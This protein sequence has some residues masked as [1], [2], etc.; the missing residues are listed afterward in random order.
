LKQIIYG[1]QMSI[2]GANINSAVHHL[3]LKS[4]LFVGLLFVI[5]CSNNH[6]NSQI[7]ERDGLLYLQGKDE[8]FSGK[9]VDTLV[10]RILE[11]E[12][13]NGKKNGEF[14]ITSLT[15][16]VM[17]AGNIKDNLNEGLWR[18]YYPN[19][20]V[21]S[22]GNFEKNLSVGKW[23]W[24]FENGKIREIGYFKSGKKDGDWTIYNEEG[25]IARKIYFKDGQVTEDKDFNK[26]L[27]S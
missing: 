1:G 24:Y 21:E 18:Y 3:K 9:I 20:Q 23:V 27:I 16:D 7:E 11:Y 25:D 26:G 2:E 19:G 15:G 5:G 10:Q 6:F 22:A 4:L 17:M 13:V 8:L 12:V 14:R